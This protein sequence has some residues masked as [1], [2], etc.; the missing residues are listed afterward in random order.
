[1]LRRGRRRK[2]GK[3]KD[4]GTSTKATT[5]EEAAALGGG[6]GSGSASASGASLSSSSSSSSSSLRS[7]DSG[8]LGDPRVDRLPGF[9]GLTRAQV[10]AH[11]LPVL[12]AGGL[13]DEDA[14][15]A[16]AEAVR[17]RVCLDANVVE[18]ASP[19]S[20]V[21]DIHGYRAPGRNGCARV[22]W[23][24]GASVA[25]GGGR[26]VRTECHTL[27]PFFFI[28]FSRWLVLRCRPANRQFFDLLELF[29]VGGPIPD[30]NYLFLGNYVDRGAFSLEG[31]KDGRHFGRRQ[32]CVVSFLLH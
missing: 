20:I 4:P 23:W 1:M 9:R 12:L 13:L 29:A 14:L 15:V 10:D 19:V 5:W 6:G 17:D 32:D 16:V 27:T 7:V 30:T 28:L 25:A 2:A 21:G 31:A 8:S 22:G 11:V 3:G 26:Y 24:R 18:V